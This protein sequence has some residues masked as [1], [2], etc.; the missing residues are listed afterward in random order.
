MTNNKPQVFASNEIL[1]ATL[2]AK[3]S[4]S[5]VQAFGKDPRSFL[6]SSLDVD[7]GAVSLHMV[8]NNVDTVNLALP[9]YSQL[10]SISASSLQEFDMGSVSGGEIIISLS[11]IGVSLGTTAGFITAGVAGVH[12]AGGKNLD[13]S[14][15]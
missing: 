13:G 1:G 4:K 3:M 15:K 11:I 10:G 5:D 9:Y 7:T 8:E 12:A 2:T 14:D 6:A